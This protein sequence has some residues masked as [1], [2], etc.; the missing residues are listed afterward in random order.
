MSPAT[1]RP[2]PQGGRL[3]MEASPNPSQGGEPELARELYYNLSLNY[4]LCIVNYE[5]VQGKRK[6]NLQRISL[7]VVR[8]PL[9]SELQ[10]AVH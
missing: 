10:V 7:H 3:L 5:L 8:Y 2:K 1:R 6:P 9:L 4:E